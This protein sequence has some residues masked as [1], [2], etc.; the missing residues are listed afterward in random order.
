MILCMGVESRGGPRGRNLKKVNFKE[1]N[2]KGSLT[3]IF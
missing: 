3:K 1:Q 2:F